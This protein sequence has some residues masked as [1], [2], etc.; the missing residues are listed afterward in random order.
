MSIRKLLTKINDVLR[1]A[2]VGKPEPTDMATR[3]GTADSA[4]WNAF[5]APKDDYRKP[6]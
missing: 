2:H 6:H 3:G 4:P 1:P 5:S